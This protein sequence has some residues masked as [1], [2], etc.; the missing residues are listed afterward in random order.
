MIK[1]GL[2][3]LLD[4]ILAYVL[5]VF[6]GFMLI[7]YL[8]H[9]F[10]NFPK[11]LLYDLGNLVALFAGIAYLSVRYK[12]DFKTPKFTKEIIKKTALWGSICGVLLGLANFPYSVL[13]GKAEVPEKFFIDPKHGFIFTLVYL[14]I[15][16]L[17]IPFIEEIFFRGLVYR[18]VRSKFD[19]FWGVIASTGLFWI[20]HNFYVPI[21]FSSLLYCYVY[22]KTNL[23]G[24]CILAHLINNLFWFSAVYY[25]AY[26]G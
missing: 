12:V 1:T 4:L 10:D 21:I 13:S 7:G 11:I 9:F 6:V 17:A 25:R 20:S 3:L 26:L 23:L 5:V 8:L 16:V 19:I 18:I 15:V 24:A 14:L 2:W 22:E